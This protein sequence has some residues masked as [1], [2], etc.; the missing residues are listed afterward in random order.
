[1]KHCTETIYVLRECVCV[2]KFFFSV[3][4][5]VLS[6]VRRRCIHSKLDVTH[7]HI[8]RYIKHIVFVDWKFGT[9][10]LK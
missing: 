3:H 6:I 4:V 10:A 7:E 8:A 9:D 1:M 2:Y 5:Y